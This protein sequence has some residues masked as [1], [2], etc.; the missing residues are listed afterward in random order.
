VSPPSWAVV[1]VDG[2]ERLVGWWKEMG[3]EGVTLVQS[4]DGRGIVQS[5]G[6]RG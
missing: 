4:M 5:M 1:V 3:H 2:M 6:G